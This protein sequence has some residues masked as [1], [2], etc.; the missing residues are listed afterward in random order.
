M[1]AYSIAEAHSYRLRHTAVPVRAGAPSLRLLHLSD[2]H[3]SGLRPDLLRWLSDLPESVG[4]VD[5]AIATGD[6]IDDDSGIDLAVDALGRIKSRL[7]RY[8]VLGSHDYFQSTIRGL[9]AGVSSMY[10]ARRAP[11][12]SRPADTARLEAGLK[13]AGWISL[14][15]AVETVATA[16]GTVRLA[17]VDDPFLRRHETAHIRREAADALA[18][19]VVH[20]PDIVSECALQGF[21]LVLAGHTHGGQVRMPGIGALV[22]NCTLPAGLARGLH[23]VGSAHLHVS[24]G[25]G[26]TKFSPVR[27]LCPPEATVLELTPHGEP[28]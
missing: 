2:T 22:T 12:T 8:Y 16:Q 24:P 14:A 18:V 1:G 21:D 5:L 19:A 28:A 6:L 4:E 20:C 7:G 10:A 25:L 9:I 27:L 3:L 15:N 23:R 26:T 17:G 13:E 11:E